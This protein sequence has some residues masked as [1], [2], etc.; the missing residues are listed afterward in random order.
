[1]YETIAK[2]EDGTRFENI[3]IPNKG[4]RLYL[5]AADFLCDII[6]WQQPLQD[7][8]KGFK[9]AQEEGESINES[10]MSFSLCQSMDWPTCFR[11]S[12]IFR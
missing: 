3:L 10:S 1:M 11:I 2:P 7:F 4:T 12:H 5:S 8:Q 9:H 6:N